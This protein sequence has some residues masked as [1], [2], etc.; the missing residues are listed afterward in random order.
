MTS[1][2]SSLDP[3][4]I[5]GDLSIYPKA[6]DTPD[7]LYQV[8]NNASSVTTQGISYNSK[9][10][11]VQ[12]A[13]SFPTS[14]LIKVGEETVYY[15]SR[16]DI[17]F[18]ELVR[19][20]SGSRQ[21]PWP[22]GTS[23]LGSV[24]AEVHNAEKDAII[25]IE[26]N[27]GTSA[28]PTSTSLNGI[29]QQQESRF[30]APTPLFRAFPVTGPAPLE[31]TFQNLS[32]GNVVS[33]LWDF[34]DGNT[35]TEAS[36]IHNYTAIGAY[37]VQLSIVTSL[38]AQ[39]IITKTNYINIGNNQAQA[40]FYVEPMVGIAGTT[41]FTFIDQTD[42]DIASRYWIFGDGTF[43]TVSDPDVHTTT[44]TYATAGSYSPSLLVVFTDN[45][46]KNLPLGDEIIVQ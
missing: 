20:F 18:K 43:E 10:I 13:S 27:I 34:G 3:G 19:G 6:L 5:A 16:T 32:G 15:A 31:V 14:G 25:N 39:G 22:K 36:P 24:F 37:T 8:A 38:G 41:V 45:T 23:V 42:G 44:H 17:A 21:S 12:D 33:Y 35:S 29:L 4:Y 26:N 40:F 1:R 30:L 2:I 46:K 7:L 9:F 11:V 28:A